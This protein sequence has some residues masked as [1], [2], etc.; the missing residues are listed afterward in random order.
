MLGS[1]KQLMEEEQTPEQKEEF[2]KFLEQVREEAKQ[3]ALQNMSAEQE[4]QVAQGFMAKSGKKF[5]GN[6]GKYP[7]LSEAVNSDQEKLKRISNLEKWE[8]ERIKI[9]SLIEVFLT[10]IG[11]KEF[12]NSINSEKQEYMKLSTSRD[13]ML[14]GIAGTEAIISKN[15]QRMEEEKLKK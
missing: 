11:M 10:K 9:Y 1:E 8:I 2:N 12:A 5:M 13:G 14:L 3:E 7:F 15:T 6:E 4:L